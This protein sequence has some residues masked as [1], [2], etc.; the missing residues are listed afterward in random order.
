MATS[1]NTTAI[2]FKMNSTI[3]QRQ[4]AR[5]KP[6][7]IDNVVKWIET[8]TYKSIFEVVNDDTYIK[9]YFDWDFN[10]K[11]EEEKQLMENNVK[12]CVNEDLNKLGVNHDEVI[13]AQRTGQ[14]SNDKGEYK[15]KISYRA[16]L[17]NKKTTK[18]HLKIMTSKD[19]GIFEK[20]KFSKYMDR[21]IYNANFIMG[22]VDCCKG[23]KQGEKYEN[24]SFDDRVLKVINKKNYDYKD[25]L[26]NIVSADATEL[27]ISD[28]DTCIEEYEAKKEEKAKT[29][30]ENNLYT[31]STIKIQKLLEILSEERATNY[32]DWVK[33]AFAL[34][35]E[36]FKTGVCFKEIFHQFSQKCHY[37]YDSYTINNM[38][39]N[40]KQRDD[41]ITLGSLY[42]WAEQDNPDEYKKIKYE[43]YDKL[44][45][46]ALSGCDTDIAK[47]I[48]H[49]TGHVYVCVHIPKE[50]YEFKAHRWHRCHEGYSLK[51]K[52]SNEICDEFVNL[53]NKLNKEA[54]AEE[55]PDKSSNLHNKVT[56]CNSIIKLLK[57]QNKKKDLIRECAELLYNDKF[58]G[59]L[60]S[61]ANLLGF[62]NGVY[63][64]DE[65]EFRDGKIN[66]YIT[67]S[68]GY[69]YTNVKDEII[70]GHIKNFVNSVMDCK[71]MQK[72]F[73]EKSGYLLHGNKYLQD[74]D[75]HT[76]TGSNGK[77]VWFE[78]LG[79]T[80]GNY[81]YTPSID[82]IVNPD[83]YKSSGELLKIKGTRANMLSEPHD[84]RPID[85][86]TLKSLSGND[87]YQART[88]YK[89]AE[90]F[91]T[92]AHMNI[93]C[94]NLPQIKAD[95]GVERR[96]KVIEWKNKFVDNPRADPQFREYKKDDTLSIT[97]KDNVA[98]HQQ[99]MLLLL[100]TYHN[101]I[102][103]IAPEAVFTA[104]SAYMADNDIVATFIEEICEIGDKFVSPTKNKI[105]Q[106]H[107]EFKEYAR[108][109]KDFKSQKIGLKSFAKTM[110]QKGY[111]FV[112]NAND[113]TIYGIR[114][115]DKNDNDNDIDNDG[116]EP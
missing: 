100:E 83:K 46:N 14:C 10:C 8:G 95:G 50:W 38:W 27:I 110:E 108:N 3:E 68:T 15:H 58:E 79:K 70:Q 22:L 7:S 9:P 98:Y 104:S 91:R 48:N 55:Q 72:Y 114:V 103:I 67:I 16:F 5:Q 62:E 106:L 24:D 63:D 51:N 60:N 73:W 59:M 113:F 90:T 18:A 82:V 28:M 32:D 115:C 6:E 87:E 99:C 96:V 11:D 111:R 1:C 93:A 101:T 78:L 65:G 102:K 26:I 69:D 53:K 20:I 40:I 45:N 12:Q 92:Q 49:L 30:N 97:F 56:Q 109:V 112:K 29:S 2:V 36:Y 74:V 21:K 86:N 42:A 39:D 33:V 37:K 54:L 41:G 61:K 107:Q 17:T 66:D 44:L 81:C 19:Y 85:S 13:L 64:L 88:L 31:T 77:S 25:T 80:L 4:S 23:K 35:S 116:L 71:I 84:N 52:I 47:L 76:G 34:K 94:N 57:N 43:K 105:N 89:E 75:F